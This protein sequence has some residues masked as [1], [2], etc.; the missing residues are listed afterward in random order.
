MLSTSQSSA[1][2]GGAGSQLVPL[3]K[4][5]AAAKKKTRRG[6]RV[7]YEGQVGIPGFEL[8]DA[9]IDF[10]TW[11]MCLPRWIM[12]TRSSVGW[13]LRRSFSVRRHGGSMSTTV[14]PLPVPFPGCFDG[15][16]PGLS[17][18]LC[19][20]GAEQDVPWQVAILRGA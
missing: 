9:K 7:N 13:A 6:G 18:K 3:P 8:I 12:A 15:S 2:G 14:F 17:A 1:A 20:D 4:Q 10:I 19:G 5:K 11:A 16:G